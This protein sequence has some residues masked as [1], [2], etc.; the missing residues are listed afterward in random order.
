MSGMALL[1]HSLSIHSQIWSATTRTNKE[2]E[3]LLWLAGAPEWGSQKLLFWDEMGIQRAPHTSKSYNLL[4]EKK[5]MMGS[6]RG[7]RRG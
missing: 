7:S 6:Y 5:K 2:L 1:T 3:V 4:L